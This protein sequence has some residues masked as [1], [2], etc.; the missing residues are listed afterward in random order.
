MVQITEPLTFFE[1]EPWI[2]EAINRAFDG[3]EMYR[4]VHICYGHEEGQP[5]ILDLQA[6][7]LF[8]W[9]FEL[10]CE[11]IHIQMASHDFAEVGDLRGWPKDKDLGVGVID[12]EDLRVESPEKIAGWLRRTIEVVPPEQVCVSTDCALAS[13]RRVVAR[14]KLKALVQGTEI[15]RRE[16]TGITA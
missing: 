5:G 9:A 11:Q 13:M 3:V 12:I 8:P 1:P 15:V 7:R 14:N 10:D 4:T 16:L 2:I 6:N